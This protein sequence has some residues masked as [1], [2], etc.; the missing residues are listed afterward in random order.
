MNDAVNHPAHYQGRAGVECI[1][2]A[3]HL[4][5]NLGNAFKYLFRR[6]Q[7]GNPIQDCEKARWYL[8]RELAFWRRFGQPDRPIWENLLALVAAV[9][10]SEGREIGQALRLIA[11]AQWS[12]SSRYDLC[13]ADEIVGRKVAL[14][15]RRAGAT[16]P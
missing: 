16:P 10:Q 12:D 8:R 6:D 2:I 3:E 11:L 7:K 13:L 9:E 4:S 15:K 5:F 1:D 14:L